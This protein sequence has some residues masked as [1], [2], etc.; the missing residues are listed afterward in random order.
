MQESHQFSLIRDTASDVI[1]SSSALGDA[2]S[3]LPYTI[4]QCPPRSWSLGPKL[5]QAAATPND[6]KPT[7]EN[8]SV[9]MNDSMRR[10]SLSDSSSEADGYIDAIVALESTSAARTA[11]V[12]ETSVISSSAVTSKVW[13]LRRHIPRK[14]CKISSI[15]CEGGICDWLA[16]H[17]VSKVRLY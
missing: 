17:V 7:N 12:H 6:S 11:T 1:K 15:E 14:G 5:R 8:H 4:L 16:F 2:I 10:A 13:Q 3:A 9:A